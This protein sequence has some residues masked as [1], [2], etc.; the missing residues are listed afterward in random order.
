MKKGYKMLDF[1][2]KLLFPLMSIFSLLAIIQ[3][4]S[5]KYS[6]DHK[7]QFKELQQ[8]AE[9]IAPGK[10]HVILIG[11]D[12]TKKDFINSIYNL[13][14]NFRTKDPILFTEYFN[15]PDV[16]YV[17]YPYGIVNCRLAVNGL[18]DKAAS[19][20]Y[21]LFIIPN[22]A[23]WD[24]ALESNAGAR[25]FAGALFNLSTYRTH[26][27]NPMPQ[28][29]PMPPI[30]SQL[31]EKRRKEQWWVANSFNNLV[32]TPWSATPRRL[33]EWLTTGTEKNT[34]FVSFAYEF[35]Q[36]YLKR[37]GHFSQ[38]PF[39]NQNFPEKKEEIPVFM[40][41]WAQGNQTLMEA[42]FKKR[43]LSFCNAISK[44]LNEKQKNPLIMAQMGAAH[45]DGVVHCLKERFPKDYMQIT[46]YSFTNGKI[47]SL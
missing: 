1:Y 5:P 47:V 43:D 22:T 30:S 27:K 31:Y 34:Y 8:L 39:Y 7:N 42:L 4:V 3:C 2:K 46:T 6:E 26:I 10:S 37:S 36:Q 45:V 35:M 40:K 25:W 13:F 16:K 19:E 17:T 14:C 11:E 21:S 41:K 44:S 38:A 29:I 12:H 33:K 23:S 18:D 15:S 24:A 28:A 32:A 9:R 20:I